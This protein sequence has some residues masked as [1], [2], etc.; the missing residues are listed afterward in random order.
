MISNQFSRTKKHRLVRSCLI[1]LASYSSLVTAVHAQVDLYPFPKIEDGNI[2]RVKEKKPAEPFVQALSKK[3]DISEDFLT[4]TIEKGFGR[5]ELIRLILISKKSGKP[6]NELIKEREKG[7]RLAKISES[8]HLNSNAIRHEAEA[9][10]KELKQKEAKI[11][12]TLNVSTTTTAGISQTLTKS[13]T[14]FQLLDFDA[15]KQ[16]KEK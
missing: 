2:K 10:L 5:T 13:G 6:L 11:K 12:M 8:A 15:E 16:K 3:T 7:T 4:E 14:N 9:M 1:F